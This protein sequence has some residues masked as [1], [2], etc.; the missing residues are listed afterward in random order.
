MAK[1]SNRPKEKQPPKAVPASKQASSKITF[2]QLETTSWF[3]PILGLLGLL[4]GVLLFDSNLSLSGDNAQFINLGR[5]LAAG[6]G[7][8]ETLGD[9]PTPHTKYPFGFP[10]L[11]AIVDTIIPSSL[12]A[13][14]SFV[15]ILYAISIPLVYK[16]IRHYANASLSFFVAILCLA[17]TPLLNFSHQVMSEIPFLPFALLALI[18]LQR[19]H[20]DESTKT[21]LFAVLAIMAAYYIRSAGIVLVGTGVI[22]FAIH[23]KWKEAG[24][25][26]GGSLLLALPWQIRTRALGG[27]DYINQLFSVNPYQPDEGMLTFGTLI[28]RLIANAEIYGL[29]I[30]PEVFVPSTVTEPNFVLGLI[31]TGLVLYAIITGIQKRQ[32]PAIFLI[33][34]LGLYL[35]WP[36]VWSDIRFL[37]PAIPILFYTFLTTISDLVQKVNA[38]ATQKAVVIAF[39]IALAS[40]SAA[41]HELSKHNGQFPPNWKNYFEAGEWIKNNTDPNIKI[42]CRKPFLMNAITNRK[43]GGYIWESPDA[44]IADFEKNNIDIVIIDQIGFSSTLEYLVP[45]FKAHRD[46]FDIIHIVRNPDTYI[47]RFK[48]KPSPSQDEG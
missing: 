48:K 34:Y 16:F 47:L 20:E 8:S 46:R 26:A 25:I 42:S 17:S 7:L 37:I 39:L 31:F 22:F 6:Y 27:N 44:I 21:L 45:A 40:N 13:L 5:S 12:I 24:I 43:S 1:R 33:C 28:E 2:E 32:L 11:L 10:L 35:L 3:L 19:A 15:V 14:K 4:M 18:L 41:T 23:Q 36:R 9:T 29:L 38:S 30:I